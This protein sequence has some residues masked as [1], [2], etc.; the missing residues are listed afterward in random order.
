MTCCPVDR[1]ISKGAELTD[2]VKEASG[3]LAK[4]SSSSKPEVWPLGY[5]SQAVGLMGGDGPVAR[6]RRLGLWATDPKQSV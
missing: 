5:R 6:S 3:Q 4:R 1:L 2:V